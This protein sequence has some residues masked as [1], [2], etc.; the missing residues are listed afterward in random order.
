M[1]DLLYGSIWSA[2]P[3]GRKRGPKKKA[4]RE[5]SPTGS[6]SM[7]EEMMIPL[8]TNNSDKQLPPIEPDQQPED[9]VDYDN[10][11]ELTS[12]YKRTIYFKS[13]CNNKEKTHIRNITPG[14][15][16]PCSK[17]HEYHLI[18]EVC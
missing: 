1:S 2:P 6:I 3:K 5:P 11:N 4:I 12:Q 18:R 17:C 7:I 14:T 10:T 16:Y 9:A 15:Y 13:D 8:V